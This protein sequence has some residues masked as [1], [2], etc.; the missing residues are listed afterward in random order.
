MLSG[1]R[2]SGRYVLFPTKDKNWM[3]HR[4]DPPV[5]PGAE[6]MPED[7]R[8]VLPEER[9]R[10]PRNKEEYGYEFA[11]GGRRMLMYADRGPARAVA[12]DGRPAKAPRGLGE[13]LGSRRAVLDG[14]MTGAAGGETYMIFDLV[15]LDDRTLFDE[16]YERR[17]ELL[18]ELGL[19]GPHWQ[20]APVFDD[21]EA[22][23]EAAREQGLPGILAKRLDGP[24]RPEKAD[25]RLI[26]V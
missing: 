17:R 6:P 2:V 1:T 21:G 22:V 8:P 4:M 23:R 5:S 15:Y 25:W 16:P 12:A 26:P 24:Y 9:K 18:E 14:E 19:S 7:V 11:W 3:I 20:T 10:L 13:A